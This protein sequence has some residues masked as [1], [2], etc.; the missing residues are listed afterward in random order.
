[1][2]REKKLVSCATTATNSGQQASPGVVRAGRVGLSEEE[3]HS[4]G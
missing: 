3:Q 1:M 2:E 4:A